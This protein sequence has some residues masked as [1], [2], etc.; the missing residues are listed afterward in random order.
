MKSNNAQMSDF[1]KQAQMLYEFAGKPT[2]ATDIGS[3]G[4]FPGIFWAMLGVKMTLVE[5]SFNR[6]CFLKLVV[7]Q[8]Q[9]D[10]TVLN[11]D[12]FTYTEPALCLTAQ[13]FKALDLLLQLPCITRQTTIALL[14]SNDVFA[15]LTQVQHIYSMTVQERRV[16]YGVLIKL[17]L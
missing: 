8:L 9:L 12:A 14:K 16:N 7:R 10:A 17:Q 13:A 5:R 3:G 6:Y 1:F 11:V 2:H 4:G 15:E